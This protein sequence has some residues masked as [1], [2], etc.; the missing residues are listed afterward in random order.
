MYL[1]LKTEVIY[2]TCVQGTTIYFEKMKSV[3]AARKKHLE[4]VNTHCT[5]SCAMC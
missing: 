2:V 5:L 4:R 3:A 1:V